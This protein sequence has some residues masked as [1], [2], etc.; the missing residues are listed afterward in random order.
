MLT[1]TIHMPLKR[2]TEIDARIRELDEK[3]RIA[4]R[5]GGDSDPK[6]KE[7]REALVRERDQHCMEIMTRLREEF[8]VV[9]PR[10]LDNQMDLVVSLTCRVT[11]TSK[12]QEDAL[13]RFSEE[14]RNRIQLTCSIS[15]D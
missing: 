2:V 12:D 3:A 8:R 5:Q 11:L 14:Q 10:F 7:S 4:F 15:R 9:I 6:I 13:L 1:C